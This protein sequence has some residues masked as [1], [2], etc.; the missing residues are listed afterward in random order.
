[1][2]IGVPMEIKPGVAEAFGL[3]CADVQ[4]IL[5]PPAQA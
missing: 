2:Q 3:D 5:T 4:G 1:M